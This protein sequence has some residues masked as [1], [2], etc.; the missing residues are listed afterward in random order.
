MTSRFC[1]KKFKIIAYDKI[2][3]KKIKFDINST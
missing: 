3:K 2:K 1:M